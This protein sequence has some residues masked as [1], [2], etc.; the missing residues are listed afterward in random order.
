[1]EEDDPLFETYQSLKI[2]LEDEIETFE[3]DHAD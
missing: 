1:M 3:V 2:A